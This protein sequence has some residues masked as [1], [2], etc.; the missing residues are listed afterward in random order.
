MPKCMCDILTGQSHL[1][2]A[3]QF[4][5]TNL[6]GDNLTGQICWQANSLVRQFVSKPIHQ[7]TNLVGK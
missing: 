6:A 5:A 1:I 3:K 2:E 7:Q 4:G